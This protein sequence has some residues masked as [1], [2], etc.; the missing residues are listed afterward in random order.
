MIYDVG[1]KQAHICTML[2]VARMCL[3]SVLG[4][5][6]LLAMQSHRVHFILQT[7]QNCGSLLES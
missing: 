2:N 3:V 7:S 1:E 6:T 5:F 4:I